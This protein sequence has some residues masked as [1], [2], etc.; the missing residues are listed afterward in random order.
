MDTLHT[1]QVVLFTVLGVTRYVSARYVESRLCRWAW[2]LV[3]GPTEVC[4]HT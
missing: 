2:W 4:V 3:K 1:F